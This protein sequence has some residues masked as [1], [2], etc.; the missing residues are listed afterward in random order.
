MTTT[1]V[2]MR[3][4]E[5]SKQRTRVVR[6]RDA[7]DIPRVTYGLIA[8]NVLIYLAQQVKL[9]GG[10]TLYDKGALLGSGLKLENGSLQQIGIA[11]GESWRLVSGAFMHESI[12]HI[13][14]NMLILY[15]LGRMLEPA[16][17]SVRFAAVY[18]VSLFAGS[19]GAIVLTPHAYT[20]GASGA[21]FGIAGCLV[22][23]LRARGV[24]VMESGLGALIVINLLYS[25]VAS[26]ISLGG[27]VG[28]LIG[29][30]IA[31]LLLQL[32]ERRRLPDSAVLVG[33]VLLC[34]AF[35]VGAVLVAQSS[36]LALPAASPFLVPGG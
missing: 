19:L 7:T 21:I 6:L 8:V 14:L 16:I 13:G 20:V 28:G 27:H 33:C 2:G 36:A 4:P 1:P 17:G 22:V 29:G 32:A 25:A 23:E 3:C 9:S 18:A 31:G 12:L 10:E 5:C 15:W 24:S 30:A 34:A 11:H 35:A 26:G